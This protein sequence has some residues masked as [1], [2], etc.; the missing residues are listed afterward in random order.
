VIYQGLWDP[1]GG[2]FERPREYRDV[3]TRIQP[4][5]KGRWPPERCIAQAGIEDVAGGQIFSGPQP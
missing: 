5:S 4:V 2:R 1:F 3:W